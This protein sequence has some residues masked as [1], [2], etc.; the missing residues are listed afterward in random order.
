MTRQLDIFAAYLAEHDAFSKPPKRGGDAAKTAQRM[1]LAA[2]SGNPLL[3][4]LRRE[5]GWQAQ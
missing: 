5:L 4:R 2:S 3:Q 1:G